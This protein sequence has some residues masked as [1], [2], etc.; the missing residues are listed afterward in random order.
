MKKII[1]IGGGPAGLFAAVHA[2]K[3]GNRVVLLEYLARL[4]RK[5]LASGAGKCNLTN[6]LDAAAM[7]RRFPPEQRRF[8]KAALTAFPPERLLNFFRERGLDFKLVD[9]FYYFPVTER[10]SDVLNILLDALS[11]AG[12]RL[13]CAAP[14]EA[15]EVAEGRIVAVRSGDRR[16]PCDAVI[17]AGG[18]PGYPPL[19][20]RGSLY[21]V[22]QKVG[23]AVTP[24]VPA[25]CGLA[26]PEVAAAGLSGVIL[27]EI[28]L[29]LDRDNITRGT[30]LFT[31]DGISGPAVLDLAGRTAH[32]MAASGPLTLTLSLQPGMTPERWETF[33]SE[34][35]QSH[36]IR[37]VK[38]VLSNLLPRAAAEHLIGLSD[39]G[40]TVVSRLDAPRRRRLIELLTAWP[41]VVTRTD[42]WDKAMAASG[43]IARDEVEAATL[44]SRLYA[45]LFFAGEFLDVDGPCGGYNLQWAFSSGCVAG[46]GVAQQ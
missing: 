16:Y 21:Q 42:S 32:R 31:H 27:P 14:V 11:G 35:R 18:G 19:G 28:E 46:T 10:A 29:R 5:L 25:L 40:N 8:V 26:V 44:R 33:W 30:L 39:L 6:V 13:E 37:Q 17:A 23:H 34:A 2:A 15:L 4:G 43:G 41:L 22:L 45:N 1:V 20:G 36:G 12:V 9:N 3:N 38:T 24:P 7:A